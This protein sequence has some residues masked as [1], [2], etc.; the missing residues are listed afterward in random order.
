V[1]AQFTIGGYCVRVYTLDLNQHW[2]R[3]RDE[4]LRLPHVDCET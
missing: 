4:L 1:D 2:R 3:I